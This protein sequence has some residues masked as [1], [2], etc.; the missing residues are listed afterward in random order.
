MPQNDRDP[1]QS[2]H[3]AKIFQMKTISKPRLAIE[4]F[5]NP[6]NLSTE[7]FRKNYSTPYMPKSLPVLVEIPNRFRHLGHGSSGEWKGSKN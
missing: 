1:F 7:E 4:I 5:T 2:P 3:F 6:H